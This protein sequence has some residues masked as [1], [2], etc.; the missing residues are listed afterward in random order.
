MSMVKRFTVCALMVLVLFSGT[1]TAAAANGNVT[2]S[3]DAGQFV[4]APGSDRSVTDLFSE[5]KDVMPGDTLTQTILVRNDASDKVNVKIYLR[6]L[7]AHEQSQE[8]LSQLT[9]VVNTENGELFHAP[10]DQKAQL[11]DWVE[12][13]EFGP[14]DKAELTV[15]LQV[16]VTLDNRFMDA[17]GYLDWQFMVEEFPVE[18]PDDPDGPVDPE[19]PVDPDQPED[20]DKP[21]K[22]IDPDKPDVPKTGDNVNVSL[23][24]G[25][26]LGSGLLLAV[27]LWLLLKKK[28][29][30]TDE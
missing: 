21:D 22:P 18:Q 28:E 25:L 12:L 17:V 30:K 6:A 8:F 19:K 26:F 14:G 27:L 13:G 1:L 16:P 2:Y 29:K 20:P 23:F 10:A 5:F 4:F 15:T 9:L 24:A 3:G 7:G 11:D